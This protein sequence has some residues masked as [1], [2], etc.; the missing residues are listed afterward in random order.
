MDRISFRRPIFDESSTVASK[1]LILAL[2]RGQGQ[3]SKINKLAESLGNSDCIET[4]GLSRTGPK[5]KFNPLEHSVYC[6][7]ERLGSYVRISATSYAAYDARCRLLGR[8]RKRKDAW[9][10]ISL[11]DGER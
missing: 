7:R 10:A 11:A 3:S 9:R 2:P 6:G 1:S 5:P 8:F 4:Q